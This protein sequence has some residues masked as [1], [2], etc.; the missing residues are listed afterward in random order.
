MRVMLILLLGFG[1]CGG[2]DLADRFDEAFVSRDS[3]T[4]PGFLTWKQVQQMP[5][6]CLSA[7]LLGIWD[8]GEKGRELGLTDVRLASLFLPGLRFYRP[9][10]AAVFFIATRVETLDCVL[11]S[12][13]EKGPDNRPHVRHS[14]RTLSRLCPRILMPSRFCGP[15]S[16]KVLVPE[17]RHE[18]SQAVYC[19]EARQ[20]TAW[21]GERIEPSR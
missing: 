9:S 18:G 8:E 12:A 2:V 13:R 3:R 5:P 14:L 17:G 20:F 15:V 1:V 16:G 21:N 19:Q 10:G 7:L 11:K 6:P 4:E